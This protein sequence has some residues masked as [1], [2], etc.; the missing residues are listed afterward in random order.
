LYFLPEDGDKFVSVGKGLFAKSEFK[1]GD[2]IIH[3]R[4]DLISL[5]HYQD[6]ERNMEGGYCIQISKDQVLDCYR[7]MQRGECLASMANCPSNAYVAEKNTFVSAPPA[8]ARIT[9]NRR[10]K[11]V[12]LKAMRNIKID[13]E[14]TCSYSKKYVYPSQATE[15]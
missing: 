12:C 6:R 13:E 8:N 9:I 15:G 1:K 2:E 4:G 10:Y 11:T 3:Y 7:A 5:Q 14:I